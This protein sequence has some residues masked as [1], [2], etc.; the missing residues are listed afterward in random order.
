MK[1]MLRKSLEGHTDLFEWSPNG[2]NWYGINY[3]NIIVKHDGEKDLLSTLAPY[4]D[5]MNSMRKYPGF[6]IS[7]FHGAYDRKSKVLTLHVKTE[8]E[9]KNYA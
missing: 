2:H 8:S 6:F 1:V 3:R 7:V 5:A 9:V 4:R